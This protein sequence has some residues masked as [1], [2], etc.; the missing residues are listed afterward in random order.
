MGSNFFLIMAYYAFSPVYLLSVFFPS[1]YLREFMML[2]T[3]LKVAM[4][5]S[6][7]AIYLKH[8]FKRDDYSIVGFGLL[9]AFCG[10]TM[11]YYWNIMWLDAVALLPLIILGL[12][13]IIEGK[14]F[15]LY[16]VTLASL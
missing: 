3:A 11:G 16:T 7:F 1:E 4:A 2:G 15:I 12:G 8:T 6:F 13:R 9:Y 10:Y 5:G 14:G